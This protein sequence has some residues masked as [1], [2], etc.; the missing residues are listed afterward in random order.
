MNDGNGSSFDI[1]IRDFKEYSV[2][3]YEWGDSWVRLEL[4]PESGGCLVV[5]KEWISAL[6]EHT[7]KD[8]AGWHVCLDRLSAVLNDHY[9]DFPKDEWEKL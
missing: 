9:I 7:P 1:K 5:L 6:N 8:L 3:E 2:L 4:S